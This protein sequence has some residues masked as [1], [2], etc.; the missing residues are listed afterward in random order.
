MGRK[1]CSCGDCLFDCWDSCCSDGVRCCEFC[2]CGGRCDWRWFTCALPCSSYF[3]IV[4]LTILW[5]VA[6]LVVA[7]IVFPA[8]LTQGGDES[9]RVSLTTASDGQEYNG[10]CTIVS[11]N[12]T[13]AQV[14]RITRCGPCGN[15]GLETCNNMQRNNQEGPCRGA[16]CQMSCDT[17][18][19]GNTLCS[20]VR[21]WDS[22]VELQARMTGP[23]LGNGLVHNETVWTLRPTFCSTTDRNVT[24]Q[25]V[26]QYTPSSV[27]HCCI[28]KGQAHL[29]PCWSIDY[30][31]VVSFWVCGVGVLMAL[32]ATYLV[33]VVIFLF[34]RC[35]D[36]QQRTTGQ[37]IVV[38][39]VKP[40][41]PV[42][43]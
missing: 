21:Y 37:T 5:L 2:D 35:W 39:D 15:F 29:A 16:F 7:A 10:L 34:Q 13:T 31:R 4:P 22:I 40:K 41:V 1:S 33:F 9:L 32:L 43:V 18:G 42:G 30:D 20:V 12:Y 23:F 36:R 14:L 3:K 38:R 17:C 19:F 27:Q 11:R 26:D 6:S 25:C 28:R 24:R 8:T